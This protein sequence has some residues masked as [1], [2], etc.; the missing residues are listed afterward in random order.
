MKNQEY[1]MGYHWWSFVSFS[2]LWLGPL[3][4]M[5]FH[6][7]TIS[8]DG[9]YLNTAIIARDALVIPLKAVETFHVR[10]SVLGRILGFGDITISGSGGEEKTLRCISSPNDWYKVYKK[11]HDA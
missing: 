9:I 11:L 5:L 4:N 3:W 8:K 1:R 7:L 10:Q 6:K 2:M